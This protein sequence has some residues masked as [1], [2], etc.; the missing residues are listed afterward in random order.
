MKEKYNIRKVLIERHLQNLYIIP[1]AGNT[2]PLTIVMWLVH[3]NLSSTIRPRY[4]DEVTLSTTTEST[5]KA[6]AI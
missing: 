2:F 1:I 3:D 5:I 4:L 6:G